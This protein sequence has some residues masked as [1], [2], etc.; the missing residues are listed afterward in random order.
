MHCL[1]GENLSNLPRGNIYFKHIEP[2]LFDMF[3][4]GMVGKPDLDHVIELHHKD[5][6]HF[7]LRNRGHD[8]ICDVLLRFV[9]YLAIELF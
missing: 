4:C 7:G 1:R 9:D 6:L 3:G 2:F 5:I 8:C